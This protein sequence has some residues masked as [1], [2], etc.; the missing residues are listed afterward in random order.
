MEIIAKL[1]MYGWIPAV[2]VIFTMFPPRRAVVVAFILAW[3][4][5]PMAQYQFQGLPDY[6]KMS[7]T[8]IGVLLATG[9]FDP[10]RFR[11]FRPTWADLPMLVYCLVPFASSMSNGLG[12]RDGISAVL[13]Q[14]MTWGVPYF[15]GRLYFVDWASLRE[16]AIGIFFGGL[17]YLPLCLLEVWRSPFLHQWIYGMGTGADWIQSI[18]YGGWRPN[19]FMQHGLMVG[20]WMASA[21]LAGFWLWRTGTLRR[22]GNVPLAWLVLALVGTTLLCKSVGALVL[23][24]AAAAALV[25]STRW[26]TSLIIAA[27][28]IA[29]V[30]YTA[31]RGTGFWSA[32]PM[33]DFVRQIDAERGG[34]LATRVHSENLLAARARQQPIFGWG[35]WGRNMAYDPETQIKAIPDGL[36]V[37]ALGVNGVVGLAALLA[38]QLL[39]VARLIRLFPPKLWRDPRLSGVAITAM[40]LTLYAI[41][42][43]LNAMVNPIFML[44]AGGLT[45]FVSA[46][47]VARSQRRATANRAPGLAMSGQA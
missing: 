5:L 37:I 33:V 6:T 4:F 34:S 39:P 2:L 19:V 25:L 15:I 9:L 26:K 29:P 18:R 43:I 24:I 7:A 17:V 3:L 27:M 12:P 14:T 42:N 16:L 35:G 1:A 11:H 21:S 23:L 22:V 32:Q 8:C 30:I 46:L 10:D 44:C 45:G 28:L 38:L 40:M 13:V 31:V 47:H 41:D 20:A 36:W